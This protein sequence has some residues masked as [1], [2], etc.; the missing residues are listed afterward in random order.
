V[1]RRAARHS[2][3]PWVVLAACLLAAP[4]AVDVGLADA[5]AYALYEL[6]VVV[7]PGVALLMLLCPS[8]RGWAWRLAVGWGLGLA[9]EIGLFVATA[10]LDVPDAH[11]PACAGVGVVAAAAVLVRRRRR[12]RRDPTE[13]DA[14][15]SRWAAAAALAVLVLVTVVGFVDSPLPGR[16]P[17]TYDVDI[18]FALS[19]AAEAKHHWPVTDPKVSGVDFPYHTFVYFHLAGA[20]RATGVELSTVYLRLYL[21]P[22]V[23]LACLQ[24]AELARRLGPGRF[25]GAAA[26]GLAFLV[27]EL[28]LLPGRQGIFL[29]FIFFDLFVSPTFVLGVVLFGALLLALF[30]GLERSG[31]ERVGRLV[32]LL[33]LAAGCAGA[34]GSILP[35]LGLSL[36]VFL[37]VTRLRDGRW[38]RDGIAALG[39]ITAIWLV[40]YLWWYDG[41]RV[42]ATLDPLRAVDQLPLVGGHADVLGWLPGG[43]DLF[44][45]L[46]SPLVLVGLCGSLLAG[47]AIAVRLQTVDRRRVLLLCLLGTAA[48]PFFLLFHPG[49]SQMFFVYYGMLA[50]CPLAAQ[51]M[52]AG[53][54]RWRA[55]RP[56]DLPWVLLFAVVFG[57]ALALQTLL[58]VPG[59]LD[60]WESGRWY[61][62]LGGILAALVIA[63]RRDALRAGPTWLA[64]AVLVLVM[65]AAID[66]P[67]DE[68]T[69]VARRLQD[70]KDPQYQ[71]L[72]P[73]THDLEAG[74]VWLRDHT[75]SDDVVATNAHYLDPRRERPLLIRV[76]AFAERR[77]FLESWTHTIRNSELAAEDYGLPPS[78]QRLAY[79][80]RLALNRRAFVLAAPQ[81]LRELRDRYGVSA[82]WVEKNN[83]PASPKLGRRATL[84]YENA[85]CAI[86]AL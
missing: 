48:I 64:T 35:M 24:L 12:G 4:A 69:P 17:V 18:T 31:R 68:L 84:V 60:G 80:N 37:A 56:G 78:Q 72:A 21:G 30:D 7:V 58:P 51:G 9:V 73:L 55:A 47:V 8:P 57:L 77:V 26:I 38:R 1:L 19:M 34:K 13:V 22:L 63:W 76:T 39:G 44:L 52:A 25:V 15:W 85:E 86:Y 6:L 10:M 28:D 32:V 29:D 20:S 82:L 36:G 43:A 70:G 14:G 65:T 27:G 3:T 50:A 23:L 83:G 62:L 61:L 53:F 45:L 74:L 71:G 66:R 54:R 2:A 11:A 41:G 59:P 5:A 79:P 81:A 49:S 67:V 33:A 42:G 16:E 75:G 40:F 46:A